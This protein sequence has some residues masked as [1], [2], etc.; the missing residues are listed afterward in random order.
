MFFN[1][2]IFSILDGFSEASFSRNTCLTQVSPID[3]LD[4]QCE[5]D[6]LFVESA[7]FGK[8]GLWHKKI[9]EKHQE[10]INIVSFF[11]KQKI[12]TAFWCKEDPVHFNRFLDSASLFDYVFTTDI[13]CIPKYK[14]ALGH[15]RVYLLPFA[16]QPLIHNPIEK[17][18]RKQAASFAGSFY[19]RYPERVKD[20]ESMVDAITSVYDLEIFDRYH[21]SSDTNYHFPDR[22]KPFIKGSLSTEQI[23][24]AYKGYRYGINL[25]T[26]KSSES[27]FA[28][29]V[30][31]LLGSGT[32]TISN[33]SPALSFLFGDIV[34]SSDDPSEIEKN[35]SELLNDDLLRMKTALIGVRKILMEH[36]YAH[37]LATVFDKVLAV[38]VMPTLPKIKLISLASNQQEL[39]RLIE[40][41]MNQMTVDWSAVL[42]VKSFQIYD[43]FNFDSR[44]RLIKQEDSENISLI[45]VCSDCVWIGGMSSEDYYGPHYLLDLLLATR[46]SDANTICKAGFFEVQLGSIVNQQ[47]DLAYKNIDEIMPRSSIFKLDNLQT[48]S[49]KNWIDY[50]NSYRLSS[51]DAIAIDVFSYCRNAYQDGV[52]NQMII[53]TVDTLSINSGQSVDELYIKSE[54]MRI[55]LPVG[56]GKPAWRLQRLADIFNI[57]LYDATVSGNIDKY[58][59]H[60]ISE[61]PDGTTFD[62]FA[63]N[64]VHLSEFGGLEGTKFHVVAE[65]GLTIQLIVQ[66]ESATGNLIQEQIFYTN[67][68][69]Q[70]IPPFNTSF[71]RLGWRVFSSGT[72]R[73]TRFVLD[74]I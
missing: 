55:G 51:D 59:W 29:R 71:I 8:E 53:D 9:S 23:D 69:Q 19:V 49:L 35:L 24:L 2:N 40:M 41:M 5:C 44:I 20:F 50:F 13:N 30:F 15:T 74:W 25:N 67:Q 17:Y 43:D 21:N 56:Y 61:I 11:K 42:I 14:Q 54:K 72:T 18:Q 38:D 32:V 1:Y 36:T 6:L 62:L 22:Y 64:T 48:L 39:A 33:H 31:E 68:N 73:V 12:P 45:D 10:L 70:W 57:N 16:C 34:I 26:V 63:N 27:M 7:W 52:T 3:I 66:F 37:R 65:F 60:L 58:G 46:F 28:R 4:D 47:F